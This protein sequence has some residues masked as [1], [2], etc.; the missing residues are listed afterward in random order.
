MFRCISGRREI[1]DTIFSNFI[2]Q[3]GHLRI[4]R[5]SNRCSHPVCIFLSPVYVC[6]YVRRLSVSFESRGRLPLLIAIYIRA[7]VGLHS[8]TQNAGPGKVKLVGPLRNRSKG[9]ADCSKSNIRF[10]PRL[11]SASAYATDVFYFTRCRG[12]SLEEIL[13]SLVTMDTRLYLSLIHI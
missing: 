13:S 11:S 7:A 8:R 5:C 4:R 6:T 12:K 9:W 2:W 10:F 3:R 1:R